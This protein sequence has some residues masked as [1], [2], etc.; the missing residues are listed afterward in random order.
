M[1]NLI[2]ADIVAHGTK[3]HYYRTYGEKPPLVLAH[4]I[5]DDGLCWT[6]VAE[7]LAG[8]FDVIMVDARGHGKSEAP[9][10]GYTLENL[11]TELADLIQALGLKKP[12]LLGHSLGAITA[13]I[14]AG[15]FPSLPGAILLEDPPPFWN[16]DASSPEQANF[17]KSMTEWIL[18]LKRKT[19]EDLLA[20]GR[21]SN[22]GWSGA[23][24][25]PWVD[26]KHR[27]SLS[28]TNL[29]FPQDIVS[30]NFPNLIQRITCPAMLISADRDRGSASSKEDIAKLKE[31]LPQLKTAHI[32]G[33]GHSIRRD[34]FS[35][36]IE[37]VLQVLAEFRTG[38]SGNK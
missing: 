17:R 19:R 37:V 27:F 23:E 14:L 8:K 13:L 16:F 32:A 35:P 26:A 10:T 30:I 34:Q 5:T 6:P 3:L 18:G 33:A 20:E 21:S 4:G 7:V 38:S 22:P 2:S 9:E 36:Y 24:L 28:I 1:L 31:W 29:L 12:I 11:A 25:G 15:L